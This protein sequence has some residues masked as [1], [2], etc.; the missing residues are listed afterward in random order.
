MMVT[1]NPLISKRRNGKRKT[2]D[3][4][5]ESNENPERAFFKVNLFMGKYCHTVNGKGGYDKGD[6]IKCTKR[7]GLNNKI[8]TTPTKN[9]V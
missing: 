2:G 4:I 5:P 9:G 7:G 6:Y 3:D 1:V 8:K